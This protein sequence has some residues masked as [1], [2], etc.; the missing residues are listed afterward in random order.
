MEVA[1]AAGVELAAQLGGDGRGDQLARR[2]QVVEAFE[3]LVEP[4][5]DG[6]AAGLRRSAGSCAT[7]ETGRMPGTIST[8]MPAAAASSRKRKKQSGEKKNW[9]I[10]RSAPAST[11]RFRLSRS[12]VAVA[13]SGWHFGIGGDR[14][15]ERRDLLQA[16]DQLGGIGDSRPDAARYG[17]AGLRRVAAQ[18]D[19]VADAELPIVAG[20]VVDLVAAS[21]RRR[22]GARPASAR[23]P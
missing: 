13:E 18:R 20:D 2:G 23:F 7:F 17:A 5:R 16:R 4:V 12:A 11:L 1:D 10:A 8:S 6:R 14:N 21:R 15:V 9:V 3:Q 22:S 19:D